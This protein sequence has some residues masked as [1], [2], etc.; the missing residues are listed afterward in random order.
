[1][2]PINT[3][4]R[5]DGGGGFRMKF[6]IIFP[7]GSEHSPKI[8]HFLWSFFIVLECSSVPGGECSVI[9]SRFFRQIQK[10]SVFYL[11]TSHFLGKIFRLRRWILSNHSKPTIFQPF[12]HIDVQTSQFS[13]IFILAQHSLKTSQNR[14]NPPFP[15]LFPFTLGPTNPQITPFWSF[16]SRHSISE[17]TPS[18]SAG[19]C[20]SKKKDM[21][22]QKNMIFF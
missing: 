19:I 14:K 17:I 9:Y 15:H 18:D 5:C 4:S 20:S 7:R 11:K 8:S 12:D 13:A 21:H 1:M 16:S 3:W 2:Q 10:I 6:L 22:F